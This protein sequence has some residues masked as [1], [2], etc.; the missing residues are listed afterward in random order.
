VG[1][2]DS[3]RGQRKGYNGERGVRGFRIGGSGRDIV[4]CIADGGLL[5]IDR[6]DQG[7]RVKSIHASHSTTKESH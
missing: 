5:L 1:E 6:L 3:E 2:G 7:H 4:S